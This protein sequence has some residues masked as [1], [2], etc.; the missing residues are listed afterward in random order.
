MDSYRVLSLAPH[1]SLYDLTNPQHRNVYTLIAPKWEDVLDTRGKLLSF[2]ADNFLKEKTKRDQFIAISQRIE[3]DLE[4]GA[5]NDPKLGTHLQALT[6]FGLREAMS[7]FGQYGWISES[8]DYREAESLGRFLNKEP[9]ALLAYMLDSRRR[10]GQLTS[11]FPNMFLVRMV[12]HDPRRPEQD[13]PHSYWLKWFVAKF[14]EAK[15]QVDPSLVYD[16]FCRAGSPSYEEKLVTECLGSLADAAVSNML[17]ANREPHPYPSRRTLRI[18]SLNLTQRGVHCFRHIFN[19]FY[20]LQLVVE[21][22]LLPIPNCLREDFSYAKCQFDYSYIIEPW[23]E[24]GIRAKEM[25]RLK[26]RQVLLFLQ[27]L[28]SALRME[29]Q[30]YI[31]V[32]RRLTQEKVVLPN[33]SAWTNEVRQ[34]LAALHVSQRDSIFAYAASRRADIDEQLRKIYSPT[35]S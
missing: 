28:E 32:F 30:R 25:I 33:V 23:P 4:W 17:V 3:N 27:V 29:Q 18:G 13:H 12:S 15:E 31:A 1:T 2:A 5:E 22:W 7:F 8:G 10:F 19:R 24:F 20:Y 21:D 14:V 26:A 11:R 34:E 16:V 35:D 9:M 6:N